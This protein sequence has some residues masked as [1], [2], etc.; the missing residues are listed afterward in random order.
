MFVSFSSLFSLDFF[1]VHLTLSNEFFTLNLKLLSK[2]CFSID[3]KT[4]K[5]MINHMILNLTLN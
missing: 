2:F 5:L 4:K 3:P 1:I